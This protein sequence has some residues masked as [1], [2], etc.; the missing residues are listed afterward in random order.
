M[1]SLHLQEDCQNKDLTLIQVK[2]KRP[3]KRNPLAYML[4]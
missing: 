2:E 3:E 4:L 1:L